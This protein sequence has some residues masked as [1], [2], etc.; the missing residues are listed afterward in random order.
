MSFCG[1]PPDGACSIHFA[2]SVLILS[3]QTAYFKTVLHWS[4]FMQYSPYKQPWNHI[5][6]Q[7]IQTF[8]DVCYKSPTLH[9]HNSQFREKKLRYCNMFHI[10][11][12]NLF[13]IVLTTNIFTSTLWHIFIYMFTNMFRPVLWPSSG[14]WFNN[15]AVVECVTITPYI[16]IHTHIISIQ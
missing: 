13:V 7:Y 2:Q 6:T 1:W 15:T 4:T 12:S 8:L 11:W 10:I 9:T 16:Y 14:W 5:F 3:R